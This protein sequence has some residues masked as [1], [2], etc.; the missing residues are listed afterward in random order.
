[1]SAAS[2]DLGP[3]GGEQVSRARCYRRP[4]YIGAMVGLIL[5]C[6]VL[7][8]IVFGALGGRLFA[9]FEHWPWWARVIGLTAVVAG[10]RALVGL[11]ISFWAGFSRERSWGFSAQGL[12]GWL[13]DLGKGFGVALLLTA[14]ALTALVGSARLFASMWP[15][16]A[17]AAGAAMVLTLGFAAP[18]VI[19][20]LFN[21]FTPL[22]DVELA[23]RLQA[24]A[25]RAQVPVK[26]VL[27]TDASRRTRKTN[28]Y[29]SGLGKTRRLV[30]YDTLIAQASP[31]EL[32]LVLAHELGH[33]RARHLLKG[34]ILGM[35]GVAA[36]IAIFW[37]LLHSPGLRTAIG[38]PAGASDPR[39]VPFVL[40]LAV[41]LETLGMPFAAALSRRWEREA[42]RFS[43]QLTHD[44]D[45]FENTHLA[46][47]TANLADLDPPRP[48]YLA[49][50]THPTPPERI[51]TARRLAAT[52]GFNPSPAANETAPSV[53][54]NPGLKP[55]SDQRGGRDDR[56]ATGD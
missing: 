12:A 2:A 3:F 49:F 54:V 5:D 55:P 41:I 36:F 26:R 1:M 37:A 51:E 43:L 23:R 53:T 31:A 32:S 42:D 27:V 11:P 45:A 18:V 39:V 50:F 21:R 16:L 35:I 47:A 48:I 40:L 34:T 15:L 30:L 9:P 56:R 13:V 22:D 10:V 24:V 52:P 25:E 19:E 46:L 4:L 38:A 14:A 44:L 28:A 8:L 29:V 7:G 17:A 6:G 33:R 20:P